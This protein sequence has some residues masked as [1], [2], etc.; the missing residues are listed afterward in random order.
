MVRQSIRHS[1]AVHHEKNASS[2][3]GIIKWWAMI[4]VF[5]VGCSTPYLLP[6]FP[7]HMRETRSLAEYDRC[8]LDSR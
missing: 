8:S 7:I 2:A 6:K 5:I 3:P 1:G 4:G